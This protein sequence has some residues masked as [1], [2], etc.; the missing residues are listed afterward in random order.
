MQPKKCS[1]PQLSLLANMLERDGGRGKRGVCVWQCSMCIN[2]KHCTR[3]TRTARE[4][5]TTNG[6]GIFAQRKRKMQYRKS[7]FA[8]THTQR[9]ITTAW[10]KHEVVEKAWDKT[11]S[12]FVWA[13]GRKSH[14]RQRRKERRKNR[15]VKFVTYKFYFLFS[16]MC[17]CKRVLWQTQ[18]EGKWE[19]GGNWDVYHGWQHNDFELTEF[20]SER[21]ND[22]TMRRCVVG[23]ICQTNC[24][25]FRMRIMPA[26][27]GKGWEEA[28]WRVNWKW[29]Y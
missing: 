25:A 28:G 22:A 7:F 11:G 20:K 19:G 27:G 1:W 3:C 6:C 13:K 8:H 18:Q 4:H 21:G 16:R 15:V 29:A 5:T 23:N 26:G 9:H 12:L 24:K 17:G 2:G 14:E 10:P